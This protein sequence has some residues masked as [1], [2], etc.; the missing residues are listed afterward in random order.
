MLLRMFWSVLEDDEMGTYISILAAANDFTAPSAPEIAEKYLPQDTLSFG[1]GLWYV[2]KKGLQYAAPNLTQAA[3]VCC[4][5]IAI[6]VVIAVME[7]LLDTSQR[8]R[9]LR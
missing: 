8:T 7:N 3:A 2:I 6:A 9:R 5:I 1:D 4:S